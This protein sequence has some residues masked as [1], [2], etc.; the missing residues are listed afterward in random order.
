MLK[1]ERTGKRVSVTGETVNCYRAKGTAL[2]IESRKRM[3][4]HAGRGGYW[5]HT[6]YFVLDADGRELAEKQR[7]S[8][9]QAFAEKTNN[10]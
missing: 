1:W 3:I 8:D 9:A 10:G 6:S 5:A 2:S 4:P 7:L